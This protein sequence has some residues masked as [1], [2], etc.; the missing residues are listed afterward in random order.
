MATPRC[1]AV[2]SDAYWPEHRCGLV[3]GHKNLPLSDPER[4][5]RH[6]CYA[7]YWEKRVKRKVKR[8][9]KPCGFTWR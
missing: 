3:K 1:N 7:V 8:V 4:S 2:I 6:Q 5:V 9:T